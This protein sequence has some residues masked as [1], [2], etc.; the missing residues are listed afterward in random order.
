MAS[1]FDGFLAE[2]RRLTRLVQGESPIEGA[3]VGEFVANRKRLDF[4]EDL[5]L[6]RKKNEHFTPDEKIGLMAAGVRECE[7]ERA[8]KQLAVVAE[9]EL[10]PI[11]G[12]ETRGRSRISTGSGGCLKVRCNVCRGFEAT[13]FAGCQPAVLARRALGSGG[14]L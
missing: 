1:P 6:S 14:G 13:A 9:R 7:P 10:L 5:V 3:R 2:A 11:I 4:L 8:L 12:A